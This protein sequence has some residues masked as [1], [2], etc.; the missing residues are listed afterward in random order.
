M[1]D[2]KRGRRGS[3][4]QKR[5]ISESPNMNAIAQD[6]ANLRLGLP[7]AAHGFL[8]VHELLPVPLLQHRCV[9][10]Q[11]RDRER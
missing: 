7:G 6:D 9:H 11:E 3:N 8:Q 4:Q 1:G 10:L 5:S 2:F